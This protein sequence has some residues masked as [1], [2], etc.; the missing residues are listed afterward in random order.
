M[1]YK[2]NAI[3]PQK[4]GKGAVTNLAKN[5]YRGYFFHFVGLLLGGIFIEYIF[6]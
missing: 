6:L 4:Q 3:S 2:N 1:L 5:F